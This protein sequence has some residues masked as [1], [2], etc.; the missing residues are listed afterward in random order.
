M[1]SGAGY[2][3]I[4]ASSGREALA[5]FDQHP[6]VRLLVTDVVMPEMDGPALAGL[7][8]EK[9]PGLAVLYISGYSDEVIAHR[10]VLAPDVSL[11]EKPFTSHAL[12]ANVRHVLD[13][14]P[15]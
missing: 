7:L 3:V 11:L 14:A 10:G 2:E 12:L 5:K 13:R 15:R 9:A 4:V 1:L 8:L 6:E